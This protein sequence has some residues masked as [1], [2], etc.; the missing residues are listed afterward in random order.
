MITKMIE[1]LRAQ[2]DALEFP[3]Q[4]CEVKEFRVWSKRGLESLGDALVRYQA[5][6]HAWGYCRNETCAHNSH[7]TYIEGG[8][9]FVLCKQAG[10]DENAV[11]LFTTPNG[12]VFTYDDSAPR[13]HFA[14]QYCL[15]IREA[16]ND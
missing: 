14:P 4:G 1:D 7:D 5:G 15:S 9:A 13:Y 16:S 12:V 2:A 3:S 10:K 11:S 6:T 8:T